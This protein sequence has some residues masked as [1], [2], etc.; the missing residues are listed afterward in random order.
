M[1]AYFLVNAN[2]QIGLGHWMR[3]IELAGEFSRRGVS[4]VFIS[5]FVD[6][7]MN[8]RAPF[9]VDYIQCEGP[10]QAGDYAR[11]LVTINDFLVVDWDDPLFKTMT[12]Q[13]EMKKS[14]RT[15]IYFTVDTSTDFDVD[16]LIS[17]NVTSSALNY[18][19]SSSTKQLTG[20]EYFIFRD[21]FRGVGK[22]SLL[23]PDQSAVNV[24]VGF[25]GSDPKGFTQQILMLLDRFHH[26]HHIHVV[27]GELSASI[28]VSHFRSAI[29]LHRNI[30]YVS[31]VMKSCNIGFCGLGSTFYEL[32]LLGIPCWVAASSEREL[33]AYEH[34]V[35][36]KFAFG[37]LAGRWEID[38]ESFRK[39]FE[40]QLSQV[41]RLIPKRRELTKTLDGQGV[42][43]IINAVLAT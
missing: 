17:Y 9:H 3:C 39:T 25:G 19:A 34:V 22:P 8:A 41:D 16:F 29:T 27:L 30:D 43:R 18:Q 23:K 33:L 21:E 24:F 1:K 10:C 12:F 40:T 35:K 6:A 13:T 42:S 7:N 11:K 28:D 32:S 26:I 37:L 15:L 4:S 36:E 31:Q 20:L 14:A 2:K 5:S 38:E